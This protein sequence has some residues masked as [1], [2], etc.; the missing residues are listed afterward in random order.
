MSKKEIFNA[1]KTNSW[2]FPYGL[3]LKAATNTGISGAGQKGAQLSYIVV[4]S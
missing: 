1:A 4:H 2:S 3:I